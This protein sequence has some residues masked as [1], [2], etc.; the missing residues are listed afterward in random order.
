MFVDFDPAVKTHPQNV[1]LLSPIF[2][3]PLVPELRKP[4]FLKAKFDVIVFGVSTHWF[5][6]QWIPTFEVG[7]LS[8]ISS[9]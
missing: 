9:N 7:N 8:H 1:R 5:W 4:P 6:E 2:H 3:S